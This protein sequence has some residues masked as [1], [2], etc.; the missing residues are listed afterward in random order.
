MRFKISSKS[1][2]DEMTL[3]F[4]FC[5]GPE[6][7]LITYGTSP[8]KQIKRLADADETQGNWRFTRKQALGYQIGYISAKVAKRRCCALLGSFHKF[9]RASSAS[10]ILIVYI[11][12]CLPSR[13]AVSSGLSLPT[14]GP[15]CYSSTPLHTS[16]TE[17]E[18]IIRCI[19][20]W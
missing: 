4:S 6:E 1:E 14:F 10:S 11:H 16:R 12:I 9:Q 2:L 20:K 8:R 3:L 13:P 19:T 18:V 7:Q 15:T 5:L 17:Y